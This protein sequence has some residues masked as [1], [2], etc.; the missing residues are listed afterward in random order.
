M[1]TVFLLFLYLGN[2]RSRK[3]PLCESRRTLC[4]LRK[5][6]ALAKVF[7]YNFHNGQLRLLGQI[8]E[9][10]AYLHG[11]ARGAVWIDED[12]LSLRAVA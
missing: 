4:V 11:R 10:A 9:T 2:S 12:D 3:N 8:D 7:L 6:F 5:T 1:G